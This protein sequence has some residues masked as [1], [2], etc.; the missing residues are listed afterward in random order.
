MHA[1]ISQKENLKPGVFSVP[2]STLARMPADVA[3]SARSSAALRTA[4]VSVFFFRMGTMITCIQQ[5]CFG[6]LLSDATASF[7]SRELWADTD[8][9]QR[10][11]AW[12]AWQVHLYGC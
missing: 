7:K 10:K 3:A 4:S 9:L 5:R 11:Q 8:A 6:C 12:I 2:A 1:F